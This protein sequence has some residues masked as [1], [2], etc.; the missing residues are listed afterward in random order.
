M[1]V[2]IDSPL[3]IYLNTVAEPSAGILYENYIDVLYRYKPYTDVLVLDELLY[4]SKKKYG[5]PYNITEFIETAILPYTMIELGEEEY[6][7][8][9]EYLLNRN[10]KPSDALHVVATMSRGIDAIVSEDGDRQDTD[11]KKVVDIR[12]MRPVV[13]PTPPPADR[14][15]PPSGVGEAEGVTDRATRST[16]GLGR[17]AG[18]QVRR[19]AQR[20]EKGGWMSTGAK[21]VDRRAGAC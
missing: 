11:N 5:I 10:L 1:K 3:F 12:P 9:A 20:A 15:R 13:R 16:A 17:R 2:F 18:S 14:S 6:R 8:A 4:I 21:P 7:Q 19:G